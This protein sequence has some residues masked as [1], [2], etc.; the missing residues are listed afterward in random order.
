MNRFCSQCGYALPPDSAFCPA[1]GA[2]ISRRTRN[3]PAESSEQRGIAGRFFLGGCGFTIIGILLLGATCVFLLV[4]GG[5]EAPAESPAKP[6]ADYSR[7]PRS[8][9]ARLEAGADCGELFAIRNAIP[10]SSPYIPAINRDLRAVGCLST[11]STRTDT[12]TQGVRPTTPTPSLQPKTPVLSS[13][14]TFTVREYRIYRM[15]VDTPL[16][17]SDGE[18][19]RRAAERHGATVVEARKIFDKVQ[20]ILSQ[21]GWFGPPRREISRAVDWSGETE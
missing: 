9:T 6:P 18:A 2:E 20:G 14:D 8:F 21:N 1:C 5:E 7:S 12:P 15:V 13:E 10:P 11:V 3:G 19:F 4:I 16:T 17:V